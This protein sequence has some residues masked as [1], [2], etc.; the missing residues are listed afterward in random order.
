MFYLINDGILSVVKKAEERPGYI[1]RLYNGQ[2]LQ[3]ISPE[4]TFS[5]HPSV[6]EFVNLKE[7]TKESLDIANEKILLEDI[8]HN[9]FITLY[10]EF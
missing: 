4:I 6:V 1:L 10:V 5:K 3:S 9:K 7:E 2:Y 8:G